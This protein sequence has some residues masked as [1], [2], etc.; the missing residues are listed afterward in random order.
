M[1]N[2][3]DRKAV[4]AIVVVLRIDIRAIEVQVVG[5]GSRVEPGRP[6]VPVRAT[7]VERRTIVVPGSREENPIC[8]A[9]VTCYDQVMESGWKPSGVLTFSHGPRPQDGQPMNLSRLRTG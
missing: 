9:V 3:P 4:P 7:V 5:I 8:S 1:L 2:R 6:V